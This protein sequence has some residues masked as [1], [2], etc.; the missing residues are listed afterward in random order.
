MLISGSPSNGSSQTAFDSS[1][2]GFQYVH[3]IMAMTGIDAHQA[4]AMTARFQIPAPNP[5][6]VNACVAGTQNA[7]GVNLTACVTSSFAAM[8]SG[9]FRPD[10]TGFASETPLLNAYHVVAPS[11]SCALS[12]V[13]HPVNSNATRMARTRIRIAACHRQPFR[14]VKWSNPLREPA[15][16]ESRTGWRTPLETE[17]TRAPFHFLPSGKP[18]FSL[19]ATTKIPLTTAAMKAAPPAISASDSPRSNPNAA[20]KATNAISKLQTSCAFFHAAGFATSRPARNTPNIAVIFSIISCTQA[21][22][23]AVIATAFVTKY[24]I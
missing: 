21:A 6:A 23:T 20:A 2:H 8:I 11:K 1:N 16:A 14:S 13:A 7:S 22:A 15:S 5:V 18:T 17:S 10:S 12:P 3:T 9:P 24:A 4:F 19:V